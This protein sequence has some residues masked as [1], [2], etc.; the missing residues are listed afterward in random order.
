MLRTE[1]ECQQEW[2]IKRKK[3]QMQ[4]YLTKEMSIKNMDL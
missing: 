2:K 3:S 1:S 4:K